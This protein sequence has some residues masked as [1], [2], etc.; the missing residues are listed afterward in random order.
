MGKP[1][2]TDVRTRDDSPLAPSATDPSHH[3]VPAETSPLAMEGVSGAD[4]NLSPSTMTL[5]DPSA[6][7]P[8]IWP[9]PGA[10]A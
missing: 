9:T 7:S 4:A 8:S 6:V 2:P 5:E 1:L 10:V 3:D